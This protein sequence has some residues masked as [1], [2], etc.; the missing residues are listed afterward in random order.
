[1]TFISEIL[2]LDMSPPA[3]ETKANINMWGHIKLKRFC[4]V[5]HIFNKMKKLPTDREKTFAN[6]I[7]DKGLIPKIYKELSQLIVEKSNLIKKG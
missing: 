2:F 7:S 4:T 1:M 6:N 5:R 3:R